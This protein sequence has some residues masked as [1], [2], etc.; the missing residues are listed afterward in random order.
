[1]QHVL[2]IL[3]QSTGR[4]VLLDCTMLGTEEVLCAIA[5]HERKAGRKV[6]LQADRMVEMCALYSREFMAAHF[7]ASSEEAR[8][9]C[10]TG[11]G[12]HQPTKE[13]CSCLMCCGQRLS[14][15]V[16]LLKPSTQWFGTAHSSLSGTK[17]PFKDPATGIIHICYAIHS[18][19]EELLAFVETVQPRKVAS[20]NKPAARQLDKLRT[21][22]SG[23]ASPRPKRK[24]DA[25]RAYN[26]DE[27]HKQTAPATCLINP[28]R[29]LLHPATTTS[30]KQAPRYC[31]HE[32]H[33]TH[34]LIDQTQL[35]N[36]SQRSQGASRN[37]K[38]TVRDC[39]SAP[40]VQK[41]V[42]VVREQPVNIIRE[43]PAASKKVQLVQ[44][45]QPSPCQAQPLRPQV[46]SLAINLSLKPKLKT[47][48]KPKLTT[49]QPPQQMIPSIPSKVAKVEGSGDMP[50]KSTVHHPAQES[51]SDTDSDDIFDFITQ[52]K[53]HQATAIQ[54]SQGPV[55]IHHHHLQRIRHTIWQA[56]DT[57]VNQAKKPT[58]LSLDQL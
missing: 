16:L 34:Q 50:V 47:Q 9:S 40:V 10:I 57:N 4:K 31:M 12:G 33:A 15:K 42:H 46:Q 22:C 7:C 14:P 3:G 29:Q 55:P 53:N 21:R 2:D 37:A 1:M 5:R 8:V 36:V 18:S 24:Q 39:A 30:I 51:S 6:A 54:K 11:G 19:F 20:I 27:Q 13:Y 41:P 45:L 32:E 26:Q 35:H 28:K 56:N 38:T 49:D 17:S 58:F 48:P 43:Q 52:H 23:A 44:Q 25:R